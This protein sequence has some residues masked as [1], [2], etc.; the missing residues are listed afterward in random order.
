MMVI[1]YDGECGFCA[2]SI[3][4][5]WKRDREGLFHFASIQ[6]EQGRELLAQHGIHDPTLDTMYLLD[7]K[8]VFERSGAGLRICRRLPRYRVLS[9]LGLLV[10]RFL[11]DWVYDLVARNRQRITSGESCEPPPEEVRKRFLDREE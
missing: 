3:R 7:G 11:R 10:P 2:A 9:T 1:L 5:V 8:E 6:S 4:F